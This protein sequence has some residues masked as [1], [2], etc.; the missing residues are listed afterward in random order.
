MPG[1]KTGGQKA[2]LKNKLKYGDDFYANIGRVGG[3]KGH[4]RGFASLLLGSDNLTGRQRAIVAGSIGGKK[5]R[6]GKST[7]KTIK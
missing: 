3:K 1:T 4:T 6:R 2:A 5:S 7:Q